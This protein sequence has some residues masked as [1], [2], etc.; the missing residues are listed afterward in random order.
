MDGTPTNDP[1]PPFEP[2]ASA[3]QTV[4]AVYSR[5]YVRH[6]SLGPS[7]AA[8]QFE[9]GKLTVWTHSQGV[10]PLRRHGA[11]PRHA[12][13]RH[14]R[15][16]PAGPRRYGH[17]G[18]DDVALDA[19]LLAKAVPGRPVLVKWSRHD[20]NLW[21]PFGP[22]MVMKLQAGLDSA[23]EVLLWSHETWS[24]SHSARP[25]VEPGRSSLLAAHHLSRPF[26]PPTQQPGRGFHGGIHRNADPLYAFPRRRIVKHFVPDSPLRHSALRS[27]GAFSNIFASES[28]VDEVAA[29]AQIDPVAF[30]LRYLTDPRARDVV[31]T[32]AERAGWRAEPRP[33]GRGQGIAFSRYKNTMIYSAVVVEATVDPESGVVHA[34][35]A[36]AAPTPGRSSTPTGCAINWRAASCSRSAGR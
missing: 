20:E 14:P 18:A 26:A 35:R 6:A 9:D 34:E 29:A 19:A 33:A 28:F 36:V 10:Y 16:P 31:A 24:Y 32:A 1:I 7:S 22:A 13:G 15:H 11:G 5:P 12:P 23:G 2:P 17:N 4:A 25:R 21:E 30:R 3:T 27:L 8:A